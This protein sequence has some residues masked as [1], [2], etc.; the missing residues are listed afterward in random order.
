MKSSDHGLA[1]IPDIGTPA[2]EK[3]IK[4]AIKSGKVKYTMSQEC[5]EVADYDQYAYATSYPHEHRRTFSKKQKILKAQIFL[6]A[7]LG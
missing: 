3:A 4:E 6:R 7:I 1:S 5:L 2:W